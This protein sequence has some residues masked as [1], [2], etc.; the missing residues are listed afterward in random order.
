MIGR[1]WGVYANSPQNV[2]TLDEPHTL[3]RPTPHRVH[4]DRRLWRVG[5]DAANLS[6][7]FE[8]ECRHY[9][10]TTSAVQPF[11]VMWPVEVCHTKNISQVR[12]AAPLVIAHSPPIHSAVVPAL[13]VYPA[14]GVLNV[15]LVTA[16]F[17]NVVD[18]AC[19]IDGAMTAAM[20][21]AAMIDR[22]MLCSSYAI[23]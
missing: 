1:W 5:A 8:Y 10:A 14:R 18:A 19:V 20:T 2:P 17:D 6:A 9:C 3:E 13:A 7:A 22:F 16:T 4:I 12:S 23:D 15:P 11:C 21:A